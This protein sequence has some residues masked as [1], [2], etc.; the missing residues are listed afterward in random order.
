M[1]LLMADRQRWDTL[2]YA[3]IK[4]TLPA[5]LASEAPRK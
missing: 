5:K 1:L 2:S 4:T 3:E